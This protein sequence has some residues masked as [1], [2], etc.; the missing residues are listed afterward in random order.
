M[1][2]EPGVIWNAQLAFSNLLSGRSASVVVHMTLPHA[3]PNDGVIAVYFPYMYG[4]L[5][6]VIL[7][8]VA[9]L[10]GDFTLSTTN[11]VFR[12]KRAVGSGT[13]SA[14]MQD[15]VI[16]L[17]GITHPLLEGPMGPSVMLQTLDAAS[18]IIDR[19]YVDTSDN[20][21]ATARVVLSS[22]SLRVTE[23]DAT[24]AQYTVSLSAPPYGNTA[25]T[26]S[27]GDPAIKAKLVLD[28]EY[29]VFSASNWSTPAKVT[30][31]AT[32][33]NV[34]SGTFTQENIVRIGH[35][36]ISGDSS[37]TFAAVNDVSV[38]I[39]ENDFPAV[40]LSDRFLAVVEGLRNDSYI[41]SLLS[42]PS[43]DV[44]VHM[45]PR[46]SFIET[47]PDQ[48]V[49]TAS[50]W[51]TPKAVNV[52]ASVAAST[53]STSTRS[54][55]F[56]Q[57]SSTDANYNG[58]IDLVFPQNEVLVYYEPLEMKSCVEPCRAGWFPLVNVTTGDSQCVGCPLGYFCAGSCVA[59]VACPIGTSSNVE[60]A[61][62]VS[63][64]QT[65][66]TGMYAHAEGMSTCLVCPA[67]AS[68]SD[69]KA[70]P[71]PC[72]TGTY[73][74]ASETQ[75]HECPAGSFN[76]K[77]FQSTCSQCP[78]GY[79]CPKGAINAISCAQGTYSVNSGATPCEKC[80][81]GYACSDPT[82]EPVPCSSG[83]YSV[84]DSLTCTTS[85]WCGIL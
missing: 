85:V 31:T 10:S 21:L 75:C 79:Y 17:E 45:T 9:G 72:P 62:D 36:I 83:S 82:V 69:S 33:D 25:L 15:V 24:G 23:G 63:V 26:L 20:V 44:V 11:N 65:C 84:V 51:N 16:E 80:P 13:E 60:F 3:V 74:G 46:D 18:R 39:S 37:N 19:T 43:S 1:E 55:I 30:V 70:S 7:S 61:Y 50:T 12:I 59:P 27:I 81:A 28:P 32:N 4:S 14:E 73:S 6:G 71:H 56:H 64:C 57:L 5:S 41:I 78:E 42:Q 22:L 68:C 2:V 29:L 53:V 49:F 76:D 40:H 77:T 34:V 54:A 58:K 8:S 48:V 52:V 66:S 67:G 35:T 47:V 38:H